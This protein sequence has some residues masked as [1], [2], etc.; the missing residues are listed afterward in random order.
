MVDASEVIQLRSQGKLVLTQY[1]W[2]SVGRVELIQGGER[3]LVLKKEGEAYTT[4]FVEV[5]LSRENNYTTDFNPELVTTL[6]S[7][8]LRGEGSTIGEA[9]TNAW[10]KIQK[11][12]ACSPHHY[13][14]KGYKN[15]AGFCV[16]CNDFQS[17]VFNPE[18]LGLFCHACGT[19]TYY[20]WDT[21]SN[22]FGCEEHVVKNLD[23]GPLEKLL[24][25][26]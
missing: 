15:G 19:P 3:G 14:P 2:S 4:A 21:K 5:F 24:L 13:T 8:F 6:A 25:G 9:E 18:Q 26:E 22:T 10:E 20:S 16:H 17:K 12:A 11:R 1:D 7:T 23:P